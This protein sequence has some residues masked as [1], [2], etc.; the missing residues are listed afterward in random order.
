[1]GKVT[2]ILEM[3]IGLKRYRD[4]SF[5]TEEMLTYKSN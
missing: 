1:M 3:V 5:N 2:I 4:K